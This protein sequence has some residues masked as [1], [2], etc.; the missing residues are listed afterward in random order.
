MSKLPSIVFAI[1]LLPVLYALDNGLAQT[2]PMGWRSWNC[3]HL[4]V[5]DTE[6]RKIIDAV[7]AKTRKVDGVPTSLLELGYEHVGVDDGWQACGT[8][9]K[10]SYHA[11]DGTPLVN[12]TKF[13]DL[14]ALVSYAHGKGVKPGW[15]DINCH[16]LDEYTLHDDKAWAQKAYAGDAK[17]VLDAGFDGLKIDNCGDDDGAGFVGRL[18]N[19]NASGRAILIENS[20][21]GHGHGP[22]RGLPTDRD[23]CPMNF[24]RTDGDIG[25]DFGNVMSKLQHTIP[26]QNLTAPISRPG[27]WAYPDMLEVGNIGG[28]LA[29]IESRTHFGAWCVVS[30]PLILGLDI[31]DN[32]RVDSIWDIISNKE[33]IAV[34]QAWAGHPGRLVKEVSGSWQ[35]W[36]KVLPKGDQAVLV[37]NWGSKSIDVSI[38]L[39]DLDLPEKCTARDIWNHKDVG[40]IQRTWNVKALSKHDSLF[41][42]FTSA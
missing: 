32:K 29:V 5:T 10:K 30:S 19:I 16:C 27:C 1:V 33:A 36:A 42:H 7:A 15:Y 38:A 11:E 18:K 39:K 4:D 40:T 9:Y 41:Y 2:P 20:D 14:R 6:I 34:N 24:F 21:Q 17:L 35:I 28:S 8:G 22:P 31:L 26:F 3:Y 25:P 37:Y 12:K 23:W 13:P